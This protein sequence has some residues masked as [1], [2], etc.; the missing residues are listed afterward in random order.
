MA[1]PLVAFM[2]NSPD[3]TREDLNELRVV[4]NGA[5]PVA[6][7]YLKKLI[8]KIGSKDLIYKEG[9]YFSRAHNILIF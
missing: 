8:E 2:C 7:S 9:S 3:L 5:A 4:I 6:L 1:P